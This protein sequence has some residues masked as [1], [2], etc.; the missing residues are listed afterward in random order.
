[1]FKNKIKA[2]TV[3]ELTISIAVIW[4]LMM[5]TTVYLTWSDEKRRIIEAQWCATTLWW[6]MTNFVFYTLTSKNLRISSSE[7][8]SPD[9]Y[10]IQLAW[11]AWTPTNNCINRENRCDKIIF[12]YADA[13]N[14]ENI[15]EYSTISSQT[16]C[17]WNKCDLG[18]YRT[19]WNFQYIK[20]NKW[21]LPRSV[22][23]RKIFY[24][25]EPWDIND[26][27]TKKL[28]WEIIITLCLNDDCSNPKEIWK[29]VADARSQTI[30][31]KYCKFYN[32]DNSCK[33]REI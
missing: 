25:K 28:Y 4:I 24:L 26:D 7:T 33:E 23:D 11:W 13:A 30:A 17:R 14:E 32:D 12:W 18:Y 5:A 2:F 10:T 21:F 6:E 22:T 8:V 20:M 9:F 1:M 3:I 27:S 19:W 16:S 31:L 29:W 15:T